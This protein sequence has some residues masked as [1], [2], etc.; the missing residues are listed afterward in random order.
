MACAV[1]NLIVTAMAGRSVPAGTTAVTFAQRLYYAGCTLG[2]VMNLFFTSLRGGAGTVL[3]IALAGAVVG[4][5]LYLVR[6][7]HRRSHTRHSGRPASRRRR[8]R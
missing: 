8:S 4:V 3:L 2:R 5:L 6:A 1:L 7:D